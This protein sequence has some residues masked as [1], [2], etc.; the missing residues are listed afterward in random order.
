[1]KGLQRPK[2]LDAGVLHAGLYY[3]PGSLKA[4]LAVGQ[5][6]F[7]TPD[8]I[9]EAAIKAIREGKTKYTDVDGTPELARSAA[10]VRRHRATL[11]RRSPPKKSRRLAGSADEWPIA[12]AQPA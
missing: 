2:V 1:M 11:A 9:K 5:P 4:R 8:N 3:K 6:D 10:G 12:S 7:D